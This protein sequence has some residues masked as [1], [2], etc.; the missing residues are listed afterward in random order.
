[1]KELTKKCIGLISNTLVQLGQTKTDKDILVL[2]TTLA[3]DLLRDF[4][5]LSWT[6]VEEA[7][8][9]G[10][11]GDKFVLNVQTYYS[12]LRAQKKLIDEDIW[13]K[14]NQITYRPDKRMIYRSRK[15][16]G[17]LTIK[18]LLK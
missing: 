3:D 2:A 18:K 12:W 17:L 14:N 16:T 6:C 11:R 7:F 13:K 8:R 9:T 5:T 4:K 1:M 10:I 15:G